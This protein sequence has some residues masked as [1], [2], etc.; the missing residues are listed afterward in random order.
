MV[1]DRKVEISHP[2]EVSL[3]TDFEEFAKRYPYIA[4]AITLLQSKM[5]GRL[6]A[7]ILQVQILED[8]KVSLIEEKMEMA[9]T[10]KQREKRIADLASEKSELMDENERMLATHKQE[11]ACVS[12][13]LD[14]LAEKQNQ[15]SELA[16][17]Q[18]NLIRRYSEGIVRH[19]EIIAEKEEKLEASEQIVVGMEE[20][21]RVQ[22]EQYEERLNSW[23]GRE[24]RNQLQEATA[25]AAHAEEQ[26]EYLKQENVAL[27]I[28]KNQKVSDSAY[29]EELIESYKKNL[30]DMNGKHMQAAS[31]YERQ[32][33]EQIRKLN[34]TVENQKEIIVGNQD[35]LEHQ[36]AMME[37]LEEQALRHRRT[38]EDQSEIIV[39]NQEV[40]EHQQAVIEEL[41]LDAD[42]MEETQIEEVA[43][44]LCRIDELQGEH[45]DAIA[46]KGTFSKLYQSH[47]RDLKCVISVHV[48]LCANADSMTAE[49]TI[50][51][52]T[53]LTHAIARENLVRR[54]GTYC[55]PTVESEV[56]ESE[57]LLPYSPHSPPPPTVRAAVNEAPA[58]SFGLGAEEEGLHRATHEVATRSCFGSDVEKDGSHSGISSPNYA[59]N[60]PDSLYEATPVCQV[61]PEVA[62]ERFE[63][64]GSDV[65]DGGPYSDISSPSYVP[66]S[67][68][69]LYDATPPHQ[70]SP[71]AASEEFEGFG[72][73]G[74]DEDL[75]SDASTSEP[76]SRKYSYDD[77][78]ARQATPLAD[79]EGGDGFESAPLDDGLY[80]N[81]A[82]NTGS[83]KRARSPEPQWLYNESVSWA[84]AP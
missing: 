6:A 2:E 52:L 70:V 64:I 60:S 15:Q 73:D 35:L 59:P 67:P 74:G 24:I 61:S 30:A 25:K 65:E 75:Y 84:K 56:E 3:V 57:S 63:G 50:E 17:R 42:E 71:E 14:D 21:F 53:K 51:R 82:P 32:C 27:V 40:L 72:P 37:E 43:D 9:A 29:L 41:E 46:E 18:S 55:Q 77:I 39:G 13:L 33:E 81:E 34:S 20:Q 47:H 8:D 31:G 7:R 66:H 62:Y 5:T 54:L 22:A 69:S 36:Q 68:D 78:S 28:S 1:T 19:R 10:L 45:K 83:R 79:H 12:N 4:N 48:P 26:I 80:D 58:E 49:A 11:L 38:V 44:L 23:Q 76:Q 16:E